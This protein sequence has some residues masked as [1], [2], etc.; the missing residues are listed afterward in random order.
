MRVKSIDFLDSSAATAIYFNDMTHHVE[1]LQLESDVLEQ[2]S[3]HEALVN[4]QLTISHEFRTPLSSSLM[5]LE[6]LMNNM[7]D[8]SSKQ[9]IHIIR[10]QM[11]LLLYLVNDILDFK[12]IEENNFIEKEELFSPLKT[13]EFIQSLFMPQAKM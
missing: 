8:E 11:N 1:R 4:Y 10:Q 9:I 7:L 2:K 3:K 5:F 6:S 12:M 13:F